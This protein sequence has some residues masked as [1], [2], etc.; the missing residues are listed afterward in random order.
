MSQRYFF[1]PAGI[2]RY[3][4]V[5][6]PDTKFKTAGE[7]K[8]DLVVSGEE[9]LALRKKIDEAVDAAFVELTKDMTPKDAKAHK[10]DYPYIVEEDDNGVATGNIIFKFRQNATITIQK[11]Q[12]V[13]QVRIG[14]K[15][16][17]G[18]RDTDEE[19]TGGSTVVVAFAMR[20]Y[21]LASQKSISVRL[22][23][24]S[25][26]LIKR[27]TGGEGIVFDAV[28]GGF[29]DEGTA[30]QTVAAHPIEGDY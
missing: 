19:V 27:G 11:T 9:A 5:N 8:V 14:L 1:S 23:F 21:R 22:D 10:K 3:P 15:D 29:V 17:S 16:S 7:Y 13:K 28:E 30:S 12:E 26:Q 24:A 20:P 2:A 25:V 18:K 6:K 4:W